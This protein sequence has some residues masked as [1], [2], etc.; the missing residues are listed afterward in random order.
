MTHEEFTDCLIE[1]IEK[2]CTVSDFSQHHAD[3][4]AFPRT[5][6]CVQ[7]E[8]HVGNENTPMREQTSDLSLSGCYVKTVVTTPVGTNLD[9]A[10]W[11]GAEKVMIHAIVV[12]CYPH[13]GNGIQF[14]AM[15]RAVRNRVRGFLGS[16]SDSD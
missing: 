8:L 15:P 6:V 7:T 14:L 13:I 11:L 4:R 2:R 16:R 9:V 1:R 3:R 5:K 10:L 12:T